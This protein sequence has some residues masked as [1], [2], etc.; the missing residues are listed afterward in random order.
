MFSQPGQSGGEKAVRFAV[1]LGSGT[2]GRHVAS[3]IA[4]NS[5]STDQ[6]LQNGRNWLHQRKNM[7]RIMFQCCRRGQSA[8]ARGSFTTTAL[9]HVQ[10]PRII[11]N[12]SYHCKPSRL[13]HTCSQDP[14]PQNACALSESTGHE[15]LIN[16]YE[17][18]LELE[19]P[20]V[21]TIIYRQIWREP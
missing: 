9:Y 12:L 18:Y 20:G 10:P 16:S 4:K 7:S 11:R 19:I 13:P 17:G 8:A 15:C 6:S 3:S 5:A 21:F 14:P 1:G 2:T